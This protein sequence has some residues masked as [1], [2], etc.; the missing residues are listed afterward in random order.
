MVL[1]VSND[2]DIPDAFGGITL[3]P[4]SKANDIGTCLAL[5]GPGGVGKTTLIGKVAERYG[6]MLYIDAEG[7]A[8]VIKHVP[9]VALAEVTKWKEILDLSRELSRSPMTFKSVCLDNMSEIQN[10]CLLSITTDMPQ[11]QHFG[12]CT[13]DMLK[14]TRTF[15]EFSRMYGI[16]VFFSVWEDT[17]KSETGVVTK[18]GVGFTPSLSRQFPGIV[19]MVGHVSAI[20]KYPGIRKLSFTPSPKSDSKFR[21]S[22]ADKAASIP[23]E[24]WVRADGNPLADIIATSTEG[25]KFPSEKYAE[26]K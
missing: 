13:A 10:M 18:K 24:L 26:P 3:V 21:V 2:V 12:K 8:S 9:N 20:D 6:P 14:L 23:T 17:E 1:S 7:G 4:V 11:I 22:P 15:R 19:N 5:Y 25:I 16:H